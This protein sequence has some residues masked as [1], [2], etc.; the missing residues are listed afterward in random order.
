SPAHQ[1]LPGTIVNDK[2]PPYATALGG[3]AATYIDNYQI[4]TAMPSFVGNATYAGEQLLIWRPNNTGAIFDGIY[5]G[6][7][8]SLQSMLPLTP[9][10][11]Q[12]LK[13]R[14]PAELLIYGNSATP[15]PAALRELRHYR[16]TLMRAGVLHAGPLALHLWL[17]RLGLFYGAPG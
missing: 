13:L 9:Y 2:Q 12:K 3:S 14:R 17:I 5:H 15:Y 1:K 8:N 16:P 11:R 4:V 7:F 10:D 6:D